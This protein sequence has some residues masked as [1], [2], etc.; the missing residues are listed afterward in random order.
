MKFIIQKNKSNNQELGLDETIVMELIN[1]EKYS[2]TYKLVS[3]E[4]LSDSCDKEAI[5]IGD[6]VFVGKYLELVHGIKKINPIEIPICLRSPEFLGREYS[7]VEKKDIP[8]SGRYFIKDVTELKKF[9]YCGEAELLWE[10]EG[11]IKD[12]RLYQVSEC[13]D[14]VA[15]YRVIVHWDEIIRCDYYDGISPLIFPDIK[16]INKAVAIYS[17]EPSRPKSYTMD[18]AVTSDRKT[19]LLE[20]HDFISCGLYSTVHGADLLYAYRDGI[21]WALSKYNVKLEKWKAGD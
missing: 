10:M 18:I 12:D 19:C 1:R 17:M 2:H 11:L 6:L 7:I 14:I 20:I 8:K 4:E 15:E 16:V 9:T 13:I 21:D 5:C 3:L